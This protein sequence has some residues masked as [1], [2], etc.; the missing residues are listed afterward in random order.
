MSELSF[1][2]YFT[3]PGNKLITD[4]ESPELYRYS[5]V[6]NDLIQLKAGKPVEILSNSRESDALKIPVKLIKPRPYVVVEGFLIFHSQAA[7]TIFDIRFFIDTP[8]EDIIKRRLERRI[9]TDR[10]DSEV[11]IRGPLINGYK[12]Y[13]LPQREKADEIIDGSLSL[14]E[15]ADTILARILNYS[16]EVARV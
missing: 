15:V 7:S 9:G 3:K 1:D 5:D 12:N 16:D 10:W 14:D 8:Q 4:W 2:D 13:V 6:E 11:Y